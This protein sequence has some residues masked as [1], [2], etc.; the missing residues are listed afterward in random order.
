MHILSETVLVRGTTFWHDE[1]G[2][3]SIKVEDH[4]LTLAIL[5]STVRWLHS[6]SPTY[7]VV[8]STWQTGRHFVLRSAVV[9]AWNVYVRRNKLAFSS[10][11]VQ[12]HFNSLTAV[13]Q[14]QAAAKTGGMAGVYPITLKLRPLTYCSHHFSNWVRIIHHTDAHG[15]IYGRPM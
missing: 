15:S 1:N 13:Y 12:A 8:T 11:T 14:L 2:T 7:N 9:A 10:A 4:R 5:W 6:R 3:W